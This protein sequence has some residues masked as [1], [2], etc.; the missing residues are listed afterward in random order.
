MVLS[1]VLL[2]RRCYRV[3]QHVQCLAYGVIGHLQQLVT[4]IPFKHAMPRQCRAYGPAEQPDAVFLRNAV[5]DAVGRLGRH[6]QIQ[7]QHIAVRRGRVG[8]ELWIGLEQFLEPH[9]ALK[10]GRHLGQ[11]LLKLHRR[12]HHIRRAVKHVAALALHP[13][14][15]L[16]DEARV[17]HQHGPTHAAYAL[18]ERHVD[19]VK[20]GSNI[21]QAFAI[22]ASCFPH[23]CAV[24]VQVDVVFAAIGLDVVQG[25]PRRQLPTD[26]AHRQFVLR[27]GYGFGQCFQVI[28][29]PGAKRVADLQRVE[30]VQQWEFAALV[31]EDVRRGMQRDP[32]IAA[33]RAPR[34]PGARRWP[35]LGCR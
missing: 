31:F 33:P 22:A 12:R 11:S 20:T 29:C 15:G 7:M 9:G 17:A 19:R 3:R 25:I 2:H 21:L 6:R 24:H 8:S 28:H 35:V 23:A 16:R 1:H 18:V 27:R 34:T 32:T 30:V 13:H 10:V 14:L 4:H 26:L 5:A